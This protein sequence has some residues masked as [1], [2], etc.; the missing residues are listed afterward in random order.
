MYTVLPKKTRQKHVCMSNNVKL[1][2]VHAMNETATLKVKALHLSGYMLGNE[3]IQSCA[4]VTMHCSSITKMP[5]FALD[6]GHVAK[7]P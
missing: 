5:E 2:C 4:D 3:S 1:F 6:G 7:H